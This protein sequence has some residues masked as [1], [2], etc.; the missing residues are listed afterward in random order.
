MQS[1]L[2]ALAQAKQINQTSALSASTT[3]GNRTAAERMS[4]APIALDP[5]LRLIWIGSAVLLLAA[6][7]LLIFS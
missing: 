1:R 2:K 3:W 4:G 6:M 5:K 7:L